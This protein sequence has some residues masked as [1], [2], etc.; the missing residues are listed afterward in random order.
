MRA[1]SVESNPTAIAIFAKAPIAGFAKTRLIPRLGAAGAAQLQSV[2]IRRA[3][4]R[5]KAANLGPVSLWCMPNCSHP[6]FHEIAEEHSIILHSQAG[7]DLGARMENAFA[8]LCKT[9]PVLLMGTDC[10]AIDTKLLA[11]CAAALQMGR[12]AVFL[13][14]EDGGYILIGLK[15]PIPELFRNI[16]WTTE[17]VMTETRRRARE[18]G[19]RTEEPE[20][21]WD[22][23]RPEDYAR[24]LASGAL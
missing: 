18:L 8:L 17:R 24:A 6:F 22:I 16:P 9:M 5:A 1:S 10:V 12:D 23:D 13:P 4:E 21:L 14:V 2:L 7:E 20:I 15:K 11:R 3:V 19:L